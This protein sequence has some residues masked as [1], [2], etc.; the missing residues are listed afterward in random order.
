M[1]TQ[2]LLIED[3]TQ[4]RDNVQELLTLSGFRVATA[5][6]GRE[7]I[8]QALL[9]HPDLILC[10]IMMPNVNGYQVL[11]AIRDIRSLATVPFVFLTAKADPLD[12]RQGMLL[13]ADDYLTKPFTIDGLLKSIETRL[14]REA[15]RKAD[16]QAK[17][18]AHQ[19]AINQPVAHE[20]K[21]P[22]DGII[23]LATLLLEHDGDFDAH[24]QTAVLT[25]IKAG[26]QRLRDS[27]G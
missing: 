8:T 22:L 26:G 13:G 25:L 15:D 4:I 6:N 20:H 18:Q 2:L 19:Q 24:Q 12:M 11:K 17:L 3:D 14:Q 1:S 21:T 5:G 10:D 16:F 23:G 7:G 9:V 27:L